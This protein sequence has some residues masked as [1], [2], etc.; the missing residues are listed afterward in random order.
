MNNTSIDF[1]NTLIFNKI[2]LV[3]YRLLEATSV[4][5]MKLFGTPVTGIANIDNGHYNQF[6]SAGLNIAQMAE[7]NTK[8]VPLRVVK[9]NDII[10]IYKSISLHISNWKLHLR[11]S[12]NTDKPLF[13]S[14]KKLDLLSVAVYE[15]AKYQVINN[16]EFDFFF[17]RTLEVVPI[18]P[19]N[20]F[21][22]VT[23]PEKEQIIPER[24]AFEDSAVSDNILF[25]KPRYG[26]K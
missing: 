4:E 21:N 12:V 10:E 23:E 24:I 6:V 26:R 25:K 11:Y 5:D 20:F 3:K 8:N 15:H 16:D 2:Y 1:S 13:D 17:R 18:T 19:A 9:H 14:L 22:K 7:L